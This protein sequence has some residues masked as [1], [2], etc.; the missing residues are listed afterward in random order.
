[1]ACYLFAELRHALECRDYV[2]SYSLHRDDAIASHVICIRSI[3]VILDVKTDGDSRKDSVLIIHTVFCPVAQSQLLS[4]F[5]RLV[6]TGISSRLAE[7]CV[8]H[9]TVIQDV[10]S[11][12]QDTKR[13]NRWCDPHHR[14]ICQRIVDLVRRGPIPGGLGDVLA[15]DDVYLFQTGMSAIFHT[16]EL[17]N[18]CF[19]GQS[20]MFGFPYELTLTLLETYGPPVKFYP[21]GSDEELGQL[22]TFLIAAREEGR[23]VQ[24]IWCECASNPL[25]RTPDLRRIRALADKEHVA[26]VVDDTIGSF[27]NV[28]LIQVANIIVTSLTK[29]FSGFVLVIQVYWQGMIRL[30][31]MRQIIYDYQLKQQLDLL[32]NYLA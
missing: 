25:L 11:S 4:E 23:P 17:L 3:E 2:T 21:F 28:D 22:E 15:R 32:F 30:G 14:K 5:W 1:M 24:A 31:L 18:R 10:T 13:P 19:G 26:I 12:M 6:G 29:S 16:Q 8:K 7:Y 9:L 20:V 27:A